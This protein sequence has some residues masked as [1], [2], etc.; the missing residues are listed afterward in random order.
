MINGTGRFISA[1]EG[2]TQEWKCF[3]EGLT[4]VFVTVSKISAKGQDGLRKIQ[5]S[6]YDKVE[7]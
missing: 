4:Q 5:I 6:V 2:K 7:R 1:W 3:S